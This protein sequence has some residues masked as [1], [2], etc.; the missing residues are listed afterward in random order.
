MMVNA[1]LLPLATD[2]STPTTLPDAEMTKVLQ[3]Y[4]PEVHKAAFVLPV[5]AEKEIAKVRRRPKM[6]DA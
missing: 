2:L 5:F 4:S 1:F 6:L 3:Y